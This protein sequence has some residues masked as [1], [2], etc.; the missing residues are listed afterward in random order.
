MSPLL[1]GSIHLSSL[2]LGVKFGDRR[3]YRYHKF[4][5]LSKIIISETSPSSQE[6]V[7]QTLKAMVMEV[8]R[9]GELGKHFQFSLRNLKCES[10]KINFDLCLTV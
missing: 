7:T 8:S 3:T 6:A 5:C 10:F 1:S 9:V 2:T 4:S